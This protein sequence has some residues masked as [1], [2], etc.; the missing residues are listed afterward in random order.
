MMKA[1]IGVLLCGLGGMLAAIPAKADPV[2]VLLLTGQN[3]HAWRETTPVLQRILE[4]TRRFEVDVTE[5]PESMTF[6]SLSPYGLLLSNWNSWGQDVRVKEWPKVAQDALIAF[7]KEGKG[8]VSVHA[9]S[10][11]F[12]D[13]R[14]YQELAIT[15]WKI[16][17]TGHGKRHSFRVTPTAEKHPITGGML[18]FAIFDELWHCVP[19]PPETQILAT[20]YSSEESG[21]T[22]ADEP[23]VMVR[24][25]G[26]GRSVNILLGHD[27]QAMS[28]E[29][30]AILLSRAA[31][32]AATGRVTLPSRRIEWSEDSERLTLKVNGDT[33]WQFNYGD[34]A[35]KPYFHPLAPAG[36]PPLTWEAPPDHAWHHALWF[37]WKYI[38]GV[39]F[40][41]ENPETGRAA[42][43]TAWERPR[44]RTRRD[45]SAQ[46]R[47]DLRYEPAPG[48]TALT[49]R[50]TLSISPPDNEGEYSIDWKSV[51]TAREPEVVLDRTPI[52]GEPDGKAWGG[53]AG[54]SVRFSPMNDP[55]IHSDAAVVT[56][57][58]GKT[59]LDAPALDYSG[60]IDG[61]IYGVAILSLSG[62]SP[63]PTPWYVI[64][65]SENS[66]YYFS[67][68]LLYRSAR[69]LKKGEKLT[70]SYRIWV[71]PGEWDSG[72]LREALAESS[73]K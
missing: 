40:W 28:H 38:N 72:K 60:V 7:M 61:Q 18:P 10:S 3:N 17:E 29:S 19:T 63:C 42:G 20:A 50:R 15:S 67:P 4:G 57:S 30:F 46:I 64:G 2:R 54:L 24:E 12:Y 25:F 21:G 37:S 62:N 23:V 48:R 70:L 39:N 13:W 35:A 16:G 34:T 69:T 32:W 9:G 52:A 65:Q 11:S 5:E 31:E 41:E 66:F 47:L 36:G 49:E 14:E 1:G 51:F 55:R 45:G 33:L 6:E 27:V 8:F 71:H 53:Y 58:D 44:F 26:Q 73:S 56:L 59:N 43:V 68:A 22:G